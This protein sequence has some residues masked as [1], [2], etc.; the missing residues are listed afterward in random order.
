VSSRSTSQGLVDNSST[1]DKAIASDQPSSLT[2]GASEEEEQLHSVP[3]THVLVYEIA[4]HYNLTDLQTLAVEKLRGVISS[5]TEDTFVQVA[6]IAYND[7]DG[8]RDALQRTLFTFLLDNHADWLSSPRFSNTL[9]HHAD[10]GMLV[11]AAIG[12]MGEK[13][14]RVGEERAAE[15]EASKLQATDLQANLKQA[16]STIKDLKGKLNRSWNEVS[17]LQLELGPANSENVRLAKL[18][19][20]EKEDTSTITT[21]KGQLKT[22]KAEL[23]ECKTKS[24]SNQTLADTNYHA[25]QNCEKQ[26]NQARADSESNRTLATTNWNALQSSEKKLKA[27]EAQVA[28]KD[29][30]LQGEKASPTRAIEVVKQVVT[31]VNTFDECDCGEELNFKLQ[32]DPRVTD[33]PFGSVLKCL[34]CG[35]RHY[36]DLV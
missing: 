18:E 16:Q 7:L 28:A 27:A 26:L 4:G 12:T 10:L 33:Y 29:K 32:R 34:E 20:S 14:L 24:A 25:W 22:C 8:S 30:E 9:A 1:A 36:G 3:V 6:E 13:I 15:L 21:L 11:G 5:L 35:Y 31:L 17:R 23:Q 19:T 2:P